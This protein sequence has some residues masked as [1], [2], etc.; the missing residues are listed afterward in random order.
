[1]VCLI[2]RVRQGEIVKL[3]PRLTFYV[4]VVGKFYWFIQ[5]QKSI[6]NVTCMESLS[7]LGSTGESL[8]VWQELDLQR[9]EQDLRRVQSKGISSLAVLLLHSYTCV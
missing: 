7:H 2:L 6:S 4:Y 1:M 3:K 5:P 9:V 8:E